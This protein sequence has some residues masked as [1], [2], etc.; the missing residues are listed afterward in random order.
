M[1]GSP[2]EMDHML[3]HVVLL[4]GRETQLLDYIDRSLLSDGLS[5]FPKGVPRRHL[6]YELFSHLPIKNIYI[7]HPQH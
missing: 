2:Q 1:F 6:N 5:K 4:R 7:F 3:N